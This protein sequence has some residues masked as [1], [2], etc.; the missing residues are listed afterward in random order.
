MSRRGG[1]YYD[2]PARRAPPG[3]S[4]PSGGRRD[5]LAPLPRRGAFGG[6]VTASSDGGAAKDGGI[7]GLL[8]GKYKPYILIGATAVAALII[9]QIYT[10]LSTRKKDDEQVQKGLRA[11]GGAQASGGGLSPDGRPALTVDPSVIEVLQQQVNTY[12]NQ[13]AE[14]ENAISQKDMQMEQIAQHL[15][16][17]QLIR[18]QQQ[19]QQSGGGGGYGPETGFAPLTPGSPIQGQQQGG[20]PP[21]QQQAMGGPGGGLFPPVATREPSMMQQQQQGSM[22][23]GGGG[24]GGGQQQMPGAQFQGPLNS[25]APIGMS[26]FASDAPI[27]FGPTGGGGGNMGVMGANVQQFT[28][29]NGAGGFTRI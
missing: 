27:S 23:G 18:A 9:W 17:Q 12:Q 2:H 8:T 13:V 7:M 21:Q 26:A 20:F 4:G 5:S 3:G 16:Q 10:K 28:G 24:G 19:L 6:Q 11:L 15:Q 29:G 22:G 14:L 1:D 25:N